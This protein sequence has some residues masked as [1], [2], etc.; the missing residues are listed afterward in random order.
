MDFYF[1][2][3]VEQTIHTP[4]KTKSAM[5]QKLFEYRFELLLMA[6]VLVL[7]DR[8]VFTDMIFFT[9]I[10]WPA[11]MIILAIASYF[12]FKDRVGIVDISRT[13]LAVLSILIPVAFSFIFASRIMT[14]IA[15]G[16]YLSY[17]LLIL[18]EVLRQIFER[19][20]SNM[21]VIFGSMCGYLLL[22]V[23]AQFSFLF[24]EYNQ[25]GSFNGITYSSIPDLYDQLSYFSM[26]S[27]TTIGYG[28][29]LPNTSAAR[30]IAMIFTISGQFYMVA[31]VGIIISRYTHPKP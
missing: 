23:L 25:P 10:V 2:F 13:I 1:N 17:Y 8:A 26:V 5:K 9:K 16:I 18:I 20:E 7:F 15:F 12:I 21:S 31:L 3:A 22:I 30:L 11:N 19:T 29:I 28:D 4:I 14:L 27:I 6:L 24:I